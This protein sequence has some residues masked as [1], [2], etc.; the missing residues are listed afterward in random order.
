MT[1]C[2]Y[3]NYNQLIRMVLS[4]M[5]CPIHFAFVGRTEPS[6]A[7]FI[8]I[9]VDTFRALPYGFT[10]SNYKFTLKEQFFGFP[11]FV[12]RLRLVGVQCMPYPNRSFCLTGFNTFEG[13]EFDCCRRQ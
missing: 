2:D 4:N 7:F 8:V 1:D 3:A 6:F 12:C 5:I 9:V 11:S 13:D 10:A